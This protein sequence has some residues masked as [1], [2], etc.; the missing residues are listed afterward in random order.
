MKKQINVPTKAHLL[1]GAFFLLLLLAV[2]VIPFAL[3]QRDMTRQSVAKPKVAAN[4]AMSGTASS[5]PRF[6]AAHAPPTSATVA[7]GLAIPQPKNPL[8]RGPA[9][10]EIG[11]VSQPQLPA[12][13]APAAV[14]YDQYDNNTATAFE[15]N[16]HADDASFVDYMADDFVVPGGE[17]WTITEVD[18]MG[19]QFGAGGATF[20]VQFYT[21][22]ASNLPDVLVYDTNNGTYTTNGMDFVITIPPAVLTAGTYWVMVQGNGTNNPFNSW[23][24][25]GRSV[26]SNDTAAWQQPGNAYGR[27]CIA[28]ERKPICFSEVP[29]DFD[30]VFRL[31]GTT[32]G[33]TPTPTP[34]A[35]PTA[36]SSPTP[37][38][39]PG[40]SCPPTITESTSQEIVAGG[41]VACGP[42]LETHYW[43][44]FDMNTFTG[45]QEYDIT[46]VEFGIELAQSLSGTGQPVT[47]N[48][49]AN[50]G[51]PFPG[52][53]RTL[54]AT[55]GT[56]NVPDQAFTILNVPITATV[57]AG[58]LD[59]VMEVIVSVNGDVFLI[60]ANADPE[61]RT[62][63]ISSDPCGTPDPVPVA[64]IGFPDVH[65]VINV[66][67]S[68]PGGTPTP[69]PSP[70]VTP[71]PTPTP[72]VTPSPTPTPSVTPSV[73]P[74]P[75]ATPSV[76]PTATPGGCVFGFGYWKNHPQAWP[77]TELQLGNVTYTQ[78]QLLDIMHEPVRGNGLISLAHHLITAKLNVA[79]GSD[80]SCIQQTIA[81]AD[82][83]IGDLVVP[84]V[85]DGYLPP[86][87]V[88]A[89]KD[90]LEEY[91]EGQLCA[92][93]CDNEGSPTPS[94]SSTP[95]RIP[96]RPLQLPHHQRPPR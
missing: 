24:W 41:S 3:A 54:L 49:Y 34:T 96:R 61:T 83:L 38:A 26:Q 9:F 56:I 46:S 92:P 2:C 42:G 93:S 87:D 23:F 13:K 6:S 50:N 16:F 8:R 36:S 70:S 76:T 15:S 18:A 30:Q 32:G 64:D 37:T 63:Y 80:P 28:W 12:P 57:P 81:D 22:S 86:R 47:V 53:T 58:T 72:S 7:R 48:L 90:I 74:T 55:S 95:G 82:A 43:R 67:G 44:A 14:L 66:N 19:I 79:N 69:T 89:L 94:P 20:N 45:G 73:T 60:G 91:N 65:Y 71:S 21:N 52:G 27:N 84:P 62:S 88:N 29:G 39:T 85:G 25:T 1:R 4:T 5:S 75:S 51:A 68:C 59:L 35:S 17:T 33:G 11:K 10:V 77:V 78:E 31:V 40:G